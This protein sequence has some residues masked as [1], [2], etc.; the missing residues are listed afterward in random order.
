[1]SDYYSEILSEI[2][3]LIDD[4]EPEAAMAAIRRELRMPYIPADIEPQLKQRLRDLTYLL[5]EKKETSEPPLEKILQ[6]L[7]GKEAE[8]L[9][10]AARL[11]SRNLRDCLPEIQDYLA[12]DPCPEA[13]AMIL[14]SI[15]EQEIRDEFVMVRGGVEYTFFGD[16][17]T[18]VAQSA[19]FLRA[20]RYLKEWLENDHPDFYSMA[21]TLLIHEAYMFLPLSYEEDEA[22]ELALEMLEKVSA[23]M[24]D[25]CLYEEIRQ[26]TVQGKA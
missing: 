12:S 5:S 14:E 4:G 1:M 3:S 19:G 22:K 17:M 8:Q 16:S 20:D 24:D 26:K 7:R 11:A 18:P 23:M 25:G 10:A 21:R 2:D 13:S 6:G 15:A 9:A